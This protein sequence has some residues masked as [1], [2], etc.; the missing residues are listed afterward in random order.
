MKIVHP[1]NLLI[2][3]NSGEGKTVFTLKLLELFLKRGAFILYVNKSGFNI[4]TETEL[5]KLHDKYPMTLAIMRADEIT[6]GGIE[7]IKSDL[8]LLPDEMLKVL[9]TDNFTF[10]SSLALIEFMTYS[11]KL[12]LSVIII[13]HDVFAS[14]KIGPRLRSALKGMVLFYLGGNT[15]NL[16]MIVPPKEYDVF[17]NEVKYH[18]HRALYWN[19][20]EDT[21]EILSPKVKPVLDVDESLIPKKALA[22]S[23]ECSQSQRVS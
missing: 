18:S 16:K 15:T 11:R 20:A 3:G 14:P 23:L 9:V 22:F 2:A 7:A 17:K 13:A 1:T 5:M 4:N 10:S 6:V 8:A 12:N 19:V 21:Y